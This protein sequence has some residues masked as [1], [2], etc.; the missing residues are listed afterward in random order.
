MTDLNS[1]RLQ[2]LTS[3]SPISRSFFGSIKSRLTRLV[4]GMTA[5]FTSSDTNTR[6][7]LGASS[8]SQSRSM[9][10]KRTGCSSSVIST[11]SSFSTGCRL[12]NPLTRYRT[13]VPHRTMPTILKTKNCGGLLRVRK[14]HRPS[15]ANS[16]ISPR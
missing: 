9:N 5:A 10:P 16:T 6:L 7:G 15:S 13:N 8:S 2:T 11:R 3:P 1:L 14:H 4:R 12:K